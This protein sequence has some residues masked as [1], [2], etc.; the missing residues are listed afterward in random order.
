MTHCA[1]GRVMALQ[2]SSNSVCEAAITAQRLRDGGDNNM[3][4]A[5]AVVV[6][7]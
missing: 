7:W 3:S 2:T 5:A 6:A 4:Q 1:E